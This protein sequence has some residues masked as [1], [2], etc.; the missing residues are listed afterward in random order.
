ME[1]SRVKRILAFGANE[2]TVVRI[3]RSQLN[4]FVGII[5]SL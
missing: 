5:D 3:V 4:S 1:A 2:E